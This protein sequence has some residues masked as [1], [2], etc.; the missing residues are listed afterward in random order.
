MTPCGLH[1]HGVAKH[2][3]PSVEWPRPAFALRGRRQRAQPF[4]MI[5][6]LILS[7]CLANCQL[8]VL[9]LMF[10][11]LLLIRF[12]L[13][14]QRPAY[15]VG[16]DLCLILQRKRCC[17]NTRW[18]MQSHAAWERLIIDSCFVSRAKVSSSLEL[19]AVH[20]RFSSMK[21]CKQLMATVCNRLSF[22]ATHHV[23]APPP[24]PPF[25]CF[26]GDGALS[27]HGGHPHWN[28]TCWTDAEQMLHGQQSGY[29]R[30]QHP[31]GFSK[32]SSATPGCGQRWRDTNR[33]KWA[34]VGCFPMFSRV[35]VGHN[36]S[37]DLGIPVKKWLFIGRSWQE[38]QFQDPAS[39]P[40]ASCIDWKTQ[41][42]STKENPT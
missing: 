38:K 42:E 21:K 40:E 24:S 10:L 37:F 31:A 30:K 32:K 27:C 9:L 28:S 33:R 7:L 3:Q 36:R 4:D 6:Y 26:S 29:A 16:A 25:L 11:L 5:T 35:H 12:C 41:H 2:C 22:A 39:S 1:F 34:Y 19:F 17:R 15:K 18:I 13:Q 23:P 14:G 8:S 20:K